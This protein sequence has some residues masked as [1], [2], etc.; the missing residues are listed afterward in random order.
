MFGSF[1]LF[2]DNIYLKIVTVTFTAL[3][4]LEILNVY[5]DITTYR[6]FMGVALI[7]TCIVYLLTIGILNRILD[8]YFIFK[9]S[10]FWK[11][12]ILSLV[13]WGPFFIVSTIKKK[14]FPETIE[15]LNQAELNF[16]EME[17]KL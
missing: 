4:Y 13:A 16:T 15:K 1:V 2:P 12:P 3:I 11:I 8:I 14:C 17:E 10:I 6:W 7:S 5:L 9:A